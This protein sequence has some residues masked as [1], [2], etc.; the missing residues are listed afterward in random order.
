[1]RRNIR[2]AQEDGNIP[3]IPLNRE[4]IPVLPNEYQLAKSGEP[5]FMFDSGEGDPER[6]FTFAS[7]IEIHLYQS[8]NIGSLMEHL[9]SVQEFSFKYILYMHSNVKIF[10]HASLV[11]CRTRLK[12]HTSDFIVKFLIVFVGKVITLTIF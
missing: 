11:C 6:M 10:F 4:V 1:M 3:Q 7:E 12:Q 5:F 2:K 9:E 8:Q